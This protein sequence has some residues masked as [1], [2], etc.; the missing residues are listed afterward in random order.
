MSTNLDDESMN[1]PGTS[2]C[3]SYWNGGHFRAENAAL[4]QPAGAYGPVKKGLFLEVVWRPW[5]VAMNSGAP[6]LGV[7]RKLVSF[8]AANLAQNLLQVLKEIETIRQLVAQLRAMV[9]NLQRIGDP[10]WRDLR[11]YVLRLNQLAQQGKALAYSL[12][13]VFGRY[14]ETLPGF[15]PMEPEEFEAAYEEWTEITLDTLAATLDTAR[16]QAEG[17]VSTQEQIRD[18]Q[19]LAD[20]A[21]GNLE[22]LNVSNMLQ[23]H[24]AQEIAKLNQVLAAHMNAQNI[25]YGHRVNLEAN[26]EATTRWLIEESQRPFHAYTGE[27]GFTGLPTDWPFPCLGCG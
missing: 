12:E 17:Y 22:A 7:S 13:G 5:P 10:S 14:R 20:G 3:F 2:G 8:D 4:D 16:E 9:V 6:Y 11:S 24:M 15:V 19:I 23:G 1:I 27:E 21:E 26:H 25:Y 18:L